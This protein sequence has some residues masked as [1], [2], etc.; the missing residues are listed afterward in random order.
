MYCSKLSPSKA[1][2]TTCIGTFQELGGIVDVRYQGH[3]PDSHRL[4]EVS[5]SSGEPRRTI[6]GMRSV[7]LSVDTVVR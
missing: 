7:G 5:G 2:G 3:T 1:R 4:K 6:G